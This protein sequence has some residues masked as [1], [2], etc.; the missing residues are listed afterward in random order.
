METYS[1]GE[2]KKDEIGWNQVLQDK[3]KKEQAQKRTKEQEDKRIYVNLFNFV[4]NIRR[5]ISKIY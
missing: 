3:P 5:K 2:H 1:K 4:N